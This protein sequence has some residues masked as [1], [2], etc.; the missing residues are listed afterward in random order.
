MPKMSASGD[1]ERVAFLGVGSAAAN[2]DAKASQ[3][4]TQSKVEIL[5]AQQQQD[6]RYVDVDEALERLQGEALARMLGENGRWQA[7]WCCLL[8]AF[9]GASTMHI[10][11]YVFQVSELYNTRIL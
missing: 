6:D 2:G 3:Q 11:C 1:E 4:L 10:F 9:Q 8:S 7:F 5:A